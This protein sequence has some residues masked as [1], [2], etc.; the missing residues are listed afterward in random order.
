M[1]EMAQIAGRAGRHQTDGSFGTVAGMG[2]GGGRGG[3]GEFTEK[4][5]YAVEEHG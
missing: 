3:G 5:I 1:A 2:H 4:E